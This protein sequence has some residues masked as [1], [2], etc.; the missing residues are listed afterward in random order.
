MNRGK[1]RKKLRWKCKRSNK[2]KAQ[3][4]FKHR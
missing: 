1:H 3:A 2:G 4:A